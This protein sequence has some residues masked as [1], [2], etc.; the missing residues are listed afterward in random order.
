FDH[1]TLEFKPTKCIALGCKISPKLS[2][3]ADKVKITEGF[4]GTVKISP[5]EINMVD[6]LRMSA[7]TNDIDSYYWIVIANSGALELIRKAKIDPTQNT[8]SYEINSTQTQLDVRW[9]KD[10]TACSIV[11]TCGQ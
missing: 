1:N 5:R 6:I 9:I 4:V 11:S 2:E 3:P 10:F 8:I 7:E